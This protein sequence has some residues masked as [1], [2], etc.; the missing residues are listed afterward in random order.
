MLSRVKVSVGLGTTAARN[1][2]RTSG[3]RPRWVTNDPER[4]GDE[5]SSDVADPLG[6]NRAGRS[7]TLSQVKAFQ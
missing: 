7:C 1:I 6:E 4:S 2:K 5:Q 3:S